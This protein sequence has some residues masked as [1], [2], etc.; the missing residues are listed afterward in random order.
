MAVDPGD[1]GEDCGGITM[2]K[3]LLILQSRKFWALIVGLLVTAGIL[4]WGDPQ[5]AEW[6]AAIAGGI[7]AIYGLSVAIEDGLSRRQ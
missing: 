2:Q 3:F 6:A 1:A 7:T 4:D 5:Q